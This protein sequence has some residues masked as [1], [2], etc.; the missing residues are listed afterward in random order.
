MSQFYYN[1]KR[2]Y[3]ASKVTV[4]YHFQFTGVAVI[5]KDRQQQVLV[6]M[7]GKLIPHTLMMGT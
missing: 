4:T 3:S 6:K 2:V 1:R 7:W 5:K